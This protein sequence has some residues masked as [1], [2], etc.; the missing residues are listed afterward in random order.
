MKFNPIC[1]QDNHKYGWIK[2]CFV[3]IYTQLQIKIKITYAQQDILVLVYI[4]IIKFC[5][6]QLP[7]KILTAIY[8]VRIQINIYSEKKT[9]VPMCLCLLAFVIQQYDD[10]LCVFCFYFNDKILYNCFRLLKLLVITELSIH[11]HD[12]I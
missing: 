1:T 11:F 5:R 6:Y 12:I 7:K 2:I 3:E 10:L 8:S 9:I 4:F